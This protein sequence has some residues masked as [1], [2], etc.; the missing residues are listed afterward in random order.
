M[1]RNTREA[2]KITDLNGKQL[3]KTDSIT[4]ETT[5][6]ASTNHTLYYFNQ[7]APMFTTIVSLIVSGLSIWAITSR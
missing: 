3:K 2:I 7:Y 4:P 5:I 6:T 1:E